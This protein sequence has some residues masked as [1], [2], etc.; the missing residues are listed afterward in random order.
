LP[1]SLDPKKVKGKIVVCLRGTN[2]RVAKGVTVLQAGG[3]GMVLANDAS[4]G[5][6]VIADAHLLPA[7]H[8]SYRDG[9]LLYSYLKSTK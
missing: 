2:A 7:T 1:G 6:D 4:S 5:N 3:V 8:I 9:L